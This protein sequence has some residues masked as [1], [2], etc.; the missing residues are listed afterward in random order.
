[1]RANPSSLRTLIQG[2]TI[3]TGMGLTLA[4]IG[5]GGTVSTILADFDQ[6][7]TQQLEPMTDNLVRSNNCGSV[8]LITL[9]AQ[10]SNIA[11]FYHCCDADCRRVRSWPSANGYRSA[12]AGVGAG[13]EPAPA[14]DQS[15]RSIRRRGEEA[16]EGEQE[17]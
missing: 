10:F 16:V 12:N 9:S 11:A 7:G 2:L 13:F 8:A 6:P 5:P 4:A 14:A 15:S 3:A 1:M 17:V